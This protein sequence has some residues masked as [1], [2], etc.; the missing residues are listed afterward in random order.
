[1]FKKDWI[2][3]ILKPHGY[4]F[5][6]LRI[7]HQEVLNYNNI[8][9]VKDHLNKIKW[10]KKIIKIAIS[11]FHVLSVSGGKDSLVLLHIAKSISSNI[12]SYMFHN[13]REPD[14]ACLLARKVDPNIVMLSAY[15]G[16]RTYVKLWGEPT[17]AMRWCTRVLKVDVSKSLKTDVVIT[18]SR[19]DEAKGRKERG[20]FGFWKSQVYFHPLYFFTTRDIWFYSGSHQIE[21]WSGYLNGY[22]RMGCIPCPFD[23][24]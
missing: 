24:H 18:G 19:S 8:S 1:M 9:F 12:N 20:Y 21:Q 15:P 10:S 17:R 16:W 13:E 2:T 23:H 11:F 3:K 14:E 4:I 5:S 22:K 7:L 6:R